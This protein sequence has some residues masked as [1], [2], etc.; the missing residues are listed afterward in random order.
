MSTS[1]DQPVRQ[2]QWALDSDDAVVQILVNSGTL[3]NRAN[4]IRIAFMGDEP[5]DE[6]L[7]AEYEAGLPEPL[8]AWDDDGNER[9]ISKL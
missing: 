3:V 1:N 4:Y 6:E 5:E 2:P 7:P 9:D 8:R